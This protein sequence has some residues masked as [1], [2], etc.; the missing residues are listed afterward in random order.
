MKICPVGTAAFHADG[1]T[2]GQAEMT[3]KPTVAFL[4]F[5]KAPYKIVERRQYNV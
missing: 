4:H 5:A 1:R 2:D 3:T